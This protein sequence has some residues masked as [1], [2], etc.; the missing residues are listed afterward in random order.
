M[1]R[2]S[3]IS[4]ISDYG[5]LIEYTMIFLHAHGGDQFP[6]CTTR[7]A[8]VT[9]GLLYEDFEMRLFWFIIFA[10]VTLDRNRYLHLPRSQTDHHMVNLSS[11]FSHHSFSDHIES[12]LAPVMPP[13]TSQR[14]L[15]PSP[16]KTGIP[17]PDVCRR[18]YRINMLA[19]LR[20]LRIG[21]LWQTLAS[22]IKRL[23]LSHPKPLSPWLSRK[24][25]SLRREVRRICALLF[26]WISL[27]W[28]PALR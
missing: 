20:V 28:V 7:S 23:S 4:A 25:S 22:E 3:P 14:P 10:S 2:Q 27:V 24:K 16:G 9:G 11:P 19:V 5:A 21:V 17:S 8:P 12:S 15:L 18:L 13:D 1:M 6:P 26:A